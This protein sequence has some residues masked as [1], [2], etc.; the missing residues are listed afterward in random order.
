YRVDTS[1]TGNVSTFTTLGS[2]NQLR[3]TTAQ[4]I[5]SAAGTSVTATTWTTL[6]GCDLP[7]AGLQPGDR[8]EIRFTIT[9]TGTAAGFSFQVNWGNTTILA[10]SGVAQD[11]AVAGRAD[12]AVTASGAEISLESWG[13]VMSFLPG[14][15]TAPAQAGLEI[16]FQAA[17]SK[18]GG[19]SVA[20]TNYTVLRYPGN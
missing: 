18:G 17:L 11:A 1:V 13:T 12:A 14:I 16:V 3:T 2:T 7:A 8:I 6:G 19:D 10:R 15:L 9:H 20:L 5:C 4:V